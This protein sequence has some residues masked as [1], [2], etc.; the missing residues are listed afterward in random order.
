MSE[1]KEQYVTRLMRAKCSMGSKD[2]SNYL[3]LPVDHGVL[4]HDNDHPLM[5][6]NDHKPE[7]HIFTMGTCHSSR[8]NESSMLQD[9]LLSALVPGSLLIKKLLSGGGCPCKPRTDFP[10]INE[11]KQYFIEDSEAIT[12]ESQLT[13]YYGGTITVVLEEPGEADGEEVETEVKETPFDRLPQKMQDTIQNFGNSQDFEG[14]GQEDF[15]TMAA[16]EGAG[17]L[18]ALA[19]SGQL[20]DL[21]L[22]GI[23][24][25]YAFN[26]AQTM[27]Q[28][29]YGPDGTIADYNCAVNTYNYGSLY[30][31]AMQQGCITAYNAETL[32]GGKADLA[33]IIRFFQLQLL[34][35]GILF[36]GGICSSMIG[37]NQYFKAKGYKTKLTKGKKNT[38]KLAKKSKVSVMAC[39]GIKNAGKKKDYSM[40]VIN[41]QAKSHKDNK[42]EM[43]EVNINGRKHTVNDTQELFGENT[44]SQVLLTLEKNNIIQRQE[45]SK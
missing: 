28:G 21:S 35:F 45:E 20:N 41:N 26:A 42:K 10:W 25:N 5:N 11:K 14:E 43:L 40:A 13:C 4:F 38:S 31:Q 29:A 24:E 36:G 39:D 8:N 2:F 22:E 3:N 34:L 18:S 17:A 37:M 12:V 9:M 15:L 44:G 6:R 23:E 16:E 30:A 7:E 1:K 33:Q 27:P 19:D 32:A